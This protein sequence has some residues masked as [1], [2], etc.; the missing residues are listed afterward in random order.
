MWDFKSSQV[1]ESRESTRYTRVYEARLQQLMTVMAAIGNL[2]I[3]LVAMS[4]LVAVFCCIWLVERSPIDSQALTSLLLTSTWSLS[5]SVISL[6]RW[7]Y[8]P[9]I[10]Y[11]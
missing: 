5:V 6:P 2:K 1:L 3:Q 8:P 7:F 11:F 10:H 9:V 4:L